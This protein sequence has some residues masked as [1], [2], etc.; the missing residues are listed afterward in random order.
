[1]NM[2]WYECMRTY[3]HDVGRVRAFV[4]WFAT[5]QATATEHKLL[6]VWYGMLADGIGDYFRAILTEREWGGG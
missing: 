1:M 4:C 6:E 2:I 5:Y 3:V